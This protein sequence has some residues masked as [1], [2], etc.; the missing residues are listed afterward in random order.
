MNR[1]TAALIGIAALAT[2]AAAHATVRHVDPAHPAAQDAGSG[3]A[4]RPYRTLAYAMKRL[5]P[6]ETLE[7]AAGTYRESLMFS[8]DDWSDAPTLIRAAPGADV[9][10]KGSDVV[11]GWERVE[12]GLYAKRSWTVNS[13]QVFVNGAALR[14]IGGTILRG[15]PERRDHR[16]HKLHAGQGGIWPG[17]VAGGVAEMTDGSFHYDAASE[18]LYIRLA[19]GLPADAVVEVSVRPYLA[20]GRGLRNIHLSGLRFR[21]ANTTAESYSGAVALTGNGLRLE[22]IDV[23]HVDGNGF[24]ITGDGNV[25]RASRANYCGQ[26]GMK[27]R[28]RGNRLIDNETSFNNTRGFNK[29]WEAGGAKFVGDG[30]LRDSEVRGHRAIGNNGDGIWF[31]WMNSGNRIHASIA[32]YNAGFG[33]HYEASR[34]AHIHDNYVFGNRQRGIYLPNSSES[35]VAYNLVAGNGY[36]GIAIVDERRAVTKRKE[37]LVPR[38]NRVFGNIIAWN[39]RAAVVLPAGLLENESDY[40]LYLSDRRVPAFSLGWGSREHPVREGLPA[41]RAASGQDDHSWHRV[42]AQ[43][44]RLAGGVAAQGPEWGP[45]LA[46]ASGL[47]VRAPEGAPRAA[48][49]RP[50]PG[51]LQ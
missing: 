5:E 18:S 8:R 37:A 41:W 47:Q 43:P 35:V 48:R 17:R 16:M 38:G 44:A 45:V 4:E 9:T 11:T 14:Q 33:I 23:A 20:H 32:A 28:G 34:R 3:A 22:A 26:T 51:P 42:A 7:I 6:G 12:P 49:G 36:E 25:I 13:Q 1:L 19:D 29:W 2:A 39:G 21:H 10:I 50:K 31:D 27:V 40:N 24:D 15:Y 46:L 30:G